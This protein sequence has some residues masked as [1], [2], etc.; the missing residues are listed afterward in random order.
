MTPDLAVSQALLK[1][2]EF[3][4]PQT[5]PLLLTLLEEVFRGERRQV[6]ANQILSFSSLKWFSVLEGCGNSSESHPI[7]DQ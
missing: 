3:K 2:S 4:S 6:R 5:T 7:S 1:K